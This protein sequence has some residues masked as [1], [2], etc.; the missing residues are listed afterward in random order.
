M[1]PRLVDTF[2]FYI[3]WYLSK[4]DNIGTMKQCPLHRFVCFMEITVKRV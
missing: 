3:Q 2:L 1:H 4:A